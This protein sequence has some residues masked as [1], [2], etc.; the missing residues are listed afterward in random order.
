MARASDPCMG[1]MFPYGTFLH[2]IENS[3][4]CQYHVL[5]SLHVKF[6]Y[7]ACYFPDR[8]NTVSKSLQKS[9][10]YNVKWKI[11]Y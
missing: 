10:S 2:L 8:L 9:I 4:T 1:F 3:L 6:S 7:I 5:R 11:I